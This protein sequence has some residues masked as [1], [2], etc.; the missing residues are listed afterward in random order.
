MHPFW[1]TA[2]GDY[3]EEMVKPNGRC[4]T[5][6][7]EMMCDATMHLRT[8][9]STLHLRA[10][11]VWICGGPHLVR[12]RLG[13]KARWNCHERMFGKQGARQASVLP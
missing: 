5:Q 9:A 7:E 3:H 12:G 11:V 13:D 8:K 10:T 6:Q 1:F 4:G 2:A